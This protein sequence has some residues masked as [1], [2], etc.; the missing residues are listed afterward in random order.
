MPISTQL[1]QGIFNLIYF[2]WLHNSQAIAYFF[3]A[4]LALY[5]QYKKPSRKNL[6]FFLAF[7]IL[8]IEFQYTKHILENLESQTLQAVLEQGAQ[9]TRF[10]RL[11]KLLL[12]KFI[13]IFLYLSGWG[14]LFFSILLK[15]K[16]PDKPK[17]E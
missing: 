14:S 3:G 10:T 17:T 11:T 2:T 6:F 15:S 8:S 1:Q 12:Q 7:L 5:L 4:I 13:P 9:A 16:T